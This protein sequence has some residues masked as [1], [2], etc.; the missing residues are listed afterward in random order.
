[1]SVHPLGGILYQSLLILLYKSVELLCPELGF[2]YRGQ[3]KY[4]DSS[5]VVL[6]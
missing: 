1:M 6:I 3:V 5:C 2:G 4:F